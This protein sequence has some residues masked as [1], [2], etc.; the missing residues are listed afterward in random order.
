MKRRIVLLGPGKLI[1]A[2]RSNN[3]TDTTEKTWLL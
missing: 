2:V 3:N 1:D